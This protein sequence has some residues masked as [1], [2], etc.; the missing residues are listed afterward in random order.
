MT[1][2]PDDRRA[3]ARA[4]TLAAEAEERAA[5]KKALKSKQAKLRKLTR[6]LGTLPK[7]STP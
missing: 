3:Q 5:A 1:T 6:A 4:R 7:R 2:D